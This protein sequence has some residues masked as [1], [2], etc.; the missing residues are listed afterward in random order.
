LCIAARDILL[1]KVRLKTIPGNLHEPRISNHANAL[2][3]FTG[4]V[5]IETIIK[6][7]QK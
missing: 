4:K 1:F 5:K 6:G 3:R 2:P 7:I